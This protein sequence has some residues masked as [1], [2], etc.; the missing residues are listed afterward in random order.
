MSIVKKV[1]IKTKIIHAQ[2]NEMIN[3]LVKWIYDPATENCEST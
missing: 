1:K 2:N 3:K